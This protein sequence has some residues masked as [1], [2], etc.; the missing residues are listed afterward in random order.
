MS[1]SKLFVIVNALVFVGFGL[2]FFLMPEQLYQ[3]LTDSVPATA[4]ALVDTHAT[5]GGLSLA[6]GAV[7]LWT[8]LEDAVRGLKYVLLA[9]A[10]MAT[11]RVVGIIVAG[12][13]N[14]TMYSFLVTE[15]IVA[16]LAVVLLKRT[17]A[18]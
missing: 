4:S 10:C 2:G 16:V 8:A 5:Y 14:L 12:E 11:A 13:A 3:N 9:M 1:W 15:L 6:Y 18:G 17:S 7:L